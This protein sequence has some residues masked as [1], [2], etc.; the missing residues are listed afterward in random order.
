ML[1]ADGA[2][3][4]HE[5]RKKIDLKYHELGEGYFA[6]MEA[7]GLEP[8]EEMN[9]WRVRPSGGTP[10]QLTALRAAV[11]YIAPIDLQTLLY[12]ARGEDRSGPWLWSRSLTGSTRRAL[13]VSVVM[14]WS[15]LL[16]RPPSREEPSLS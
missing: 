13:C 8:A 14:T 7:R 3:A 5:V 11:N 15:F 1:E 6:R 9:V 12:V 10:E 4:S 2:G 16:V